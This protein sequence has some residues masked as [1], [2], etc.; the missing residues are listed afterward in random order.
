MAIVDP[1][2]AAKTALKRNVFA[3]R[4]SAYRF[5]NGPEGFSA[6]VFGTTNAKADHRRFVY[7]G[8]S[9]GRQ[10]VFSRPFGLP[11]GQIVEASFRLAF[12]AD[13]R[14]PD[15]LFFTCERTKQP[16]V[17][18]SQLEAHQNGVVGISRIIMSE[19]Y[20]SD[21]LFM[22]QE[23]LRT[24]QS[25]THEHGIDIPAANGVISVF[26]G[27]GCQ[28][29]LGIPIGAERGLRLRAIVFDVQSMSSI[30]ELLKKNAIDC[31]ARHNRIV[32]E[33]AAGQGAIFAFEEKPQ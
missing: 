23:L 32:V 11:D 10:L 24:S 5:R 3:V 31:R 17:D 19:P 8:L 27:A 16:E 18:R 4:D 15:T 7:C 20:P 25:E 12:A 2:L 13:P 22:C 9:A 1:E 30:A 21:F 29:E 14:S 6:L 33:P 26:N 28:S